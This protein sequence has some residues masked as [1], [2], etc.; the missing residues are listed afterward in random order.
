MA[1]IGFL[2]VGSAGPGWLPVE[3]IGW[4]GLWLAAILT[5]VTGW[6]YLQAGLRH[7]L[8]ERPQPAAGQGRRARLSRRPDRREP[9]M[10][11]RYF[12]WLKH[13]VGLRRG[14]ARAAAGG[15]HA[16]RRSRLWLAER[17]PGF[18]EAL[19]SPGVVRCAVNQ[20]YVPEDAP[21]RAGRRGGV[22]PAGDGRLR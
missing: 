21:L 13:R 1:A 11:I 15:R 14:G 3:A 17:H 18:A 4:W 9:P 8:Q 12:A 7:M 19:A 10:R 2:L 22:L 20:E 16:S 6:D 5:L